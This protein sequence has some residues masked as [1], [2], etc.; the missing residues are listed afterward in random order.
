MAVTRGYYLTYVTDKSWFRHKSFQELFVLYG[1]GIK[2]Q[3][4]I[5]KLQTYYITVMCY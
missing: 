4:K 5:R 3:K 2:P 1:M